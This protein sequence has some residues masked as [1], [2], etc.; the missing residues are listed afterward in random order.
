MAAGVRSGGH[1][2]LTQAKIYDRDCTSAQAV[3]LVTSIAAARDPRPGVGI[4]DGS[5]GWQ[6]R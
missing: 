3:A 2:T 1:L 5:S 6:F 4:A